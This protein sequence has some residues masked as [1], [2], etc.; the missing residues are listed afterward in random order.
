MLAPYSAD[1]ATHIA[2]QASAS[3]I[4]SA[5]SKLC[6]VFRHKTFQIPTVGRNGASVRAGASGTELWR[7]A[8]DSHSSASVCAALLRV[9]SASWLICVV[10]QTGWTATGKMQ[11]RTGHGKTRHVSH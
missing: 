10:P 6:L 9:D 8:T 4:N 3:V 7:A 5:L 11:R 2:G 1:L